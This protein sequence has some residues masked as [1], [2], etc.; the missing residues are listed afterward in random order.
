MLGSVCAR[1][2][3]RQG[4]PD[5]NLDKETEMKRLVIAASVLLLMG[6]A[7]AQNN[8]F[9]EG[10]QEGDIR[11]SEIMGATVFVTEGEVAATEVEAQPEG[12][13]SVAT[14]TDVVASR[15]GQ[16]RG[17]LLDVGG[18]LGLGA[19]TVM[20]SMDQIHLVGDASNDQFY[21]VFTATREQLEA[22]P[23]YVF[24]DATVEADQP[25]P[26]DPAAPAAPA[27]PAAPAA[28]ADPAAPAAPGAQQP[29]VTDDRFG[30]GEV[31]EGYQRADFAMLTADDLKRAQVYDRAN[32]QVAG[33]SD[34]VLS[35]DGGAV[36][37]VLI[38]IG[39]F[40]GLGARTV[41]VPLDRVEVHHDAELNDVRVYLNMTEEELEAQEEYQR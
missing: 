9:V 27:D 35:A 41:M 6:G 5:P 20:V 15:D 32:E 11:M 16:I 4:A 31:P 7:L 8:V 33:I 30:V 25:A 22:A 38:D 3:G 14:V 37:G 34:V 23:E 26:A 29:G 10:F 24:G 18:F 36:E 21:V 13:E 1:L 39:G 2:I 40:L 28:P 19:R 12:W 17:V